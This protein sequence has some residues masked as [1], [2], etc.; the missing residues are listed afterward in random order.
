MSYKLKLYYENTIHD[1]YVYIL[2]V[3]AFVREEY[4]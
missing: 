4:N 2:C 1:Y 3:Y